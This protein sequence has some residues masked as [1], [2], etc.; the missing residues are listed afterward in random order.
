MCI[1][2]LSCYHVTFLGLTLKFHFDEIMVIHIH[3]ERVSIFL[4][5]K[6]RFSLSLEDALLS[7]SF[8]SYQDELKRED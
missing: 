8:H 6:P 3:I 7:L 5:D 2:M 4:T 1:T